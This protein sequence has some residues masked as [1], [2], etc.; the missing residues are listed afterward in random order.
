[1]ALSPPSV[2]YVADFELPDDSIP[3]QAL[4]ARM[5]IHAFLE[6]SKAHSLVGEMNAAIV[7]D[8]NSKGIAAVRLPANS[9]PPKEGWLVRGVFVKV[10]EG[11]RVKRAVV[12]FGSG[13]T[14]IEVATST[15]DLSA[16]TPQPLYRAQW[17]A[18]SDKLPGAAVTLNPYVAAAKF[19][20]AGFDLD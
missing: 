17:D 20:L 4:T 12:V 5:P 16:G 14:D 11:N 8:L 3:S 7:K 15:D 2:V 13:Q 1:G 10:D 19:V 9:P 18:T 6:R